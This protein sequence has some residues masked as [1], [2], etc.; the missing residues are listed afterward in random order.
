MKKSLLLIVP[1]LLVG[2]VSC[3][4]R[5]KNSSLESTIV[6]ENSQAL[7]SESISVN[8]NQGIIDADIALLNSNVKLTETRKSIDIVK[9]GITYYSSYVVTYYDEANGYTYV[10]TRESGYN[11]FDVATQKY[12]KTTEVYYDGYSSY[13][14]SDDKVFVKRDEV[15]TNTFLKT[16][17]NF[18]KASN[19][20]IEISGSEHTLK[21]KITKDNIA[22]FYG[23]AIAGVEEISFV[24]YTDGVEIEEIEIKYVQNGYSVTQDTKFSVSEKKITLPT[25]IRKA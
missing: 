24:V 11:N 3:G 13:T 12:S 8:P 9:D 7:S 10:S 25:T 21:G 14:S 4:Q 17:L 6:S 18:E 19:V 5:K 20:E 16:G 2:L 22:S 1:V 23:K 15:T